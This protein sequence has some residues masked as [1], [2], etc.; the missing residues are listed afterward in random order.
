[1]LEQAFAAVNRVS[2]TKIYGMIAY[3]TIAPA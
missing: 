3:L 2:A 1:M